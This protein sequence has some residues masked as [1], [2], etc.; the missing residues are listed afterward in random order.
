M[1][2]TTPRVRFI[3]NDSHRRYID[4]ST[5]E[6]IPGVTS[7]I[8]NLPKP[9]LQAWAAKTVAQMAVR[10][11]PAITNLANHDPEAA[12]E[13]LKSAPRRD[14]AQ[15][16]KVGREAHEVFEQ[17]ALGNPVFNLPDYLQIYAD[18]FKDYL[19]TLQ[20]EFLLTEEGV[21]DRTHNYAGT[22]DAVVRYNNPDV[23]TMDVEGNET[24]LVG[25]AH[26]DNKTT[27][28]G[29]HAEVSLQLAAYSHAEYLVRDDG[30]TVRNKPSDLAMVLHVRPEG[31]RLVPVRA[32]YR[33][34]I[35]FRTLIEVSKWNDLQ[36]GLIGTPSAGNRPTRARRANSAE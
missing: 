6:F 30:S 31:W 27:R 19:D 8:G 16:A 13:W 20:P 33:E 7:I 1:T 14:T 26:Q 25:V 11:L 3:T 2:D 9:F 28:S 12:V 4:P 35:M 10:D 34:L 29:V 24:A 21:W 17:L 22:F 32:G 5:N 15:A 23:T 36:K 18:H